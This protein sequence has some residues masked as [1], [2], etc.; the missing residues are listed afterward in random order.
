MDNLEEIRERVSNA[1]RE[2]YDSGLVKLTWGNVSEIERER[3]LVAIKPSGVPF[4]ELQRSDIPV[5]HIL[6]GR[7]Y[8]KAKKLSVDTPTHLVLYKEFPLI[9]SIVHTHSPY[10]TAF[11]QAEKE[12]ACLGTTHADHFRGSIPVSRALESDEIV[13]EYELNIGKAIAQTFKR[14]G[15]NY[16]DVPAC[17]I[18]HHGV[19]VWGKSTD[20]AVENAI[21][22]EEVAKLNILTLQLNP[23]TSELSS[24]LRDFH[25]SRK[26]GPSKTYGQT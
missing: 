23:K 19:Y 9:K 1:N 16:L 15:L 11:A 6:N 18:P 5:V 17:L 4:N 3:G 13:N 2:I 21:V 12:I 8:M 22:L 24:N 26:H 10:A 7:E 20:K 14:K 25:Y